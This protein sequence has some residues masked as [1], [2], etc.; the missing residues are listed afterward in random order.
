[1][2]YKTIIGVEIHVELMTDTKIF[3]SCTNE[4]GGEINTHCCPVCLGLPGAIPS[5]NENVLEY[6][7]KA[8]L[9]FNCDINQKTKMDRKNYFYSDLVKG[10]QTSQDDIPLCENGYIEI[11]EDG[12]R[13]KVRIERIHIEEDTGKSVHTETGDTLL[14][15]NRAGVPLI[16]IVSKPDMSSSEEA[17]LFLEKLRNTLKYIEVSDCKMEEGSLRCDININVKNEETGEVTNI[18]EVKNLNSF[19]AA[20]KA[21][22]YEEVRHKELLEAGKNTEKDTRRWDEVEGETIVMRG[23]GTAS[24]Y[25]FAIDGDILPIEISDEWLNKVKESLPELPHEKR[26]RFVKEHGLSEYDADVL[27]QSR[28]IAIFYEETIKYNDDKIMVSNWIMGDVL[29]RVNDE[30]LDINELKFQAKDLADLLKLIQNDEISNN[31]GKKVFRTMF[32]TGKKPAE[33]VK[34]EGLSQIS[35][36]G[37]LEDIVNKV[38]DANEQSIIDYKDGK[39]RALGFLM[40]QVMKETKGQANPQM[41]NEMLR[42][43]LDQ[44]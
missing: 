26:D 44:R 5:L 1:M 43:M 17:R 42:K 39:D 24:D 23:K 20:M 2:G 28:E 21:I 6:G 36:T 18:T 9:A 4:F 33:I 11:E 13:K 35:D 8:G 22:E 30:N 3:C 29:R 41:A 38:L 31:V 25:R 40:G 15:Y 27:T 19:R 14:D 12:N 37:A 16:E 32:E 34:E 10:Y 7:M